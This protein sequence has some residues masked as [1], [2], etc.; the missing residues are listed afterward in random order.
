MRDVVGLLFGEDH[1]PLIIA[2]DQEPTT[3][4]V[5]AFIK[6]TS[7]WL[8][9]M[10][11]VWRGSVGSSVVVLRVLGKT[12]TEIEDDGVT[13]TRKP[14]GPGRYFFEVW[15]AEECSPVFD[16]ESPDDLESL[17]RTF[18]LS[19]DS[20]RAQGYDVDT[21]SAFWDTKKNGWRTRARA[22]TSEQVS[23]GAN[24]D[25][26]LR[27]VLDDAK[28]TWYQPVPRYIY[29]RNSWKES[30]WIVDDKRSFTHELL[31]VPAQWVRPL[32]INADE[33]YP[34]GQCIFEPVI[35]FQFRIDRTLSQTGRAFDY[36]GDPQLARI[37]AAGSQAA[38]GAFGDPLAVG[39][40]A[41]DVVDSP[42][43]GDL[44]FIEIQGDG[45]AVAIDSYIRSLREIARE[46]GAMSRISSD[47]KAGSSAPLSAVAM[48][49]LNFAQLVLC[50]ILRQTCGEH[51][52]GRLIRLAMRM[53][54]K[55]DVALP[56]L[57]QKKGAT[58]AK[59]VPNANLE[60]QWPE[61]YELHGQE[62]LYEVQAT[63]QAKA[64]ELI[65]QETGVANVGAMFDVQ[66]SADEIARID[67]DRTEDIN[68]EVTRTVALNAV[69]EP[70]KVIAT[71]QE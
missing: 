27:V 24:Q 36:A 2:K 19:E 7:F 17:S 52:G 65:S 66:N 57:A 29:E 50:G 34:D 25:W 43:G 38:A 61:Y 9:M 46:A 41:S 59:P 62:K 53:A 49:M 54:A 15:P 58:P 37:K 69:A 32:P 44:K 42:V 70:S 23:T 1:R 56:S 10:D 47:S 55:V 16:R 35:D 8:V 40:T 26:T 51:A 30:D 71:L 48:K 4:W 3:D 21:I 63:V 6:D 12:K 45:L 64:G 18:F 60:W 33:L 5:A 22:K 28:E 39:G 11:A 31:E 67:S 20:L 13:E 68:N 14:I